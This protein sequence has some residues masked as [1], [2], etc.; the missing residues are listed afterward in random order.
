MDRYRRFRIVIEEANYNIVRGR[1][2]ILTDT[3]V[4]REMEFFLSTHVFSLDKGKSND[5]ISYDEY[6]RI[7]NAVQHYYDGIKKSREMWIK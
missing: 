5:H 1:V 3:K 6:C 7:K 2:L 4:E